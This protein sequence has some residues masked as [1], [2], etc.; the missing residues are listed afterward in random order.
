MFAGFNIFKCLTIFAVFNNYVITHL[1]N[2][3][4]CQLSILNIFGY[5]KIWTDKQKSIYC[6]PHLFVDVKYSWSL[7]FQESSVTPCII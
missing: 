2:Y 6:A 7:I 5:I 3:T 4:K 1:H